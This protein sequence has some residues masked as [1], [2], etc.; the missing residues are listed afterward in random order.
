MWGLI[1]IFEQEYLNYLAFIGLVLISAWLLAKVLKA[2]LNRGL[3]KS[4][5][6]LNI[7]P[8]KFYFLRNAINAIILLIAVIV[9]FYGIPDL[10]S[11]GISL[12]AGAG[13]F[14][15]IVGFA[16]QQAFSNIV[17]GIFI[18]IFKPFKVGDIITVAGN[19]GS[20]EDI[21]L[22]H[23][24]INGLENRRIVIP[25]ST[26]SAETIINSSL[27][28]EKICIF[29]E[30]GV[31]YDANIDHVFQVLQDVGAQHPSFLDNRSPQD[32]ENGIPAIICRVLGFGESSIDL[33]LQIWSK[34]P[35]TAFEMKCDLYKAIKERFDQ[36]GIEIPY[37]HRT[38]V[39]KP[40]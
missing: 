13:I 17:G 5:R 39:N 34:D 40:V 28:D 4:S 25:N 36:E 33:R 16:S 37:P 21:T 15:A 8:T 11:V 24:V 38:I 20:V 23:T 26:I 22:R 12:F 2:L 30:F 10:R 29:L 1:Y 35:V 6:D 14:A 19:F 3:A 32:I 18:V 31:S 9:I 7:D 27:I